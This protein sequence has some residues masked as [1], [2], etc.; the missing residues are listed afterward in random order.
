MKEQFV[1]PLV[2]Q[3]RATARR[4]LEEQRVELVIGFE[5]GPT[6]LRNTPCFVRRTDDVDQLTW[7]HFC[8]LNL[9]V[10]LQANPLR[11]AIFAKG[12]DSRAI[13]NLLKERQIQRENLYIVGIPCSGAVEPAKVERLIEGADLENAKVE[14]DTLRVVASG[15]QFEAPVEEMLRDSCRECIQ[16][17]P[18]YFDELLDAAQGRQPAEST[19]GSNGPS[20]RAERWRYFEAQAAKCI[21]CYACRNV[22]PVCYCRECV[23]DQGMPRWIGTAPEGTDNQMFLL[24]RALHLAG[25]CVDCGTCFDV[26]PVGVDVRH[27]YKRMEREVGG[28]FGYVA[29]V[30]LDEKPPLAT[31]DAADPEDFITDV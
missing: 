2:A 3:I 9:A 31:F 18:A 8:G 21:R 12:C 22:C 7:G 25:R 1:D 4:L 26:C 29:G 6:P 20:D 14:G 23:V 19:A 10:F 5:P 16:P 28:R 17:T 30:N 15:R 13:V 11:T 27:L 24:V